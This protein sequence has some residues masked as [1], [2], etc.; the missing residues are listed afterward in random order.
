MKA[1]TG[2]PG[3]LLILALGAFGLGAC[4]DNAGQESEPAAAAAGAAAAGNPPM[5]PAGD[6][7][8][9]IR[10]ART[11]HQEA[12]ALGHGW[13]VTGDY[14][15]RAEEALEDGDGDQALRLAR[16]A[17]GTARASLEQAET[18]REAWEPRFRRLLNLP[19]E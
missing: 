15:R 9:L 18:E 3:Y 16:R 13:N 12:R 10:Q 6:P 19:A 8:D 7:S 1:T 17:L 11:L 2:L 4:T 5:D 14:L